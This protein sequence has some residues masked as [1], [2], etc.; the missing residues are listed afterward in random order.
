M[1]G[2]GKDCDNYGGE[3]ERREHF[4]REYKTTESRWLR[5]EQSNYS[6]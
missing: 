4:E 3:N 2:N 1:I 6:M 5:R